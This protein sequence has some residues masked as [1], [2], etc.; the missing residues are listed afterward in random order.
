MPHP[1]PAPF[2]TTVS[3]R[4][5]AKALRE[6]TCHACKVS[7]V[8][9][10]APAPQHALCPT[11]GKPVRGAGKAAH[12]GTQWVIGA[13]RDETA[14]PPPEPEPKPVAPQPEPKKKSSED[15]L[16]RAAEALRQLKTGTDPMEP[17]ELEEPIASELDLEPDPYEPND[18][19]VDPED[20]DAT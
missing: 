17:E 4:R 9:E 5:S 6:A 11:C 1:K 8:W 15:I 7:Y 18:S 10:G 12:H 16:E 20:P 13:P 3:F 14:P 2:D 19:P